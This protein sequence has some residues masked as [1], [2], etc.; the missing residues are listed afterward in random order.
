[1]EYGIT[2]RTAPPFAAAAARLR[3]ALKEQGFGV[4]TEIEMQA[5][6]GERSAPRWATT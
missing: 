2:V 5:T 1:M 4:L 6:L 3:N